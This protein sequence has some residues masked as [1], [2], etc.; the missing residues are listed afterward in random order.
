[1]QEIDLTL[2]QFDLPW[3]DDWRGT[4]PTAYCLHMLER[5]SDEN[6]LQLNEYLFGESHASP[7]A[8]QGRWP[9]DRFRLFLSHVHSQKAFVG[10][11]K[12]ELVSYAVEGFVAHADITPTAEWVHE[13]ELALETC[14]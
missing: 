4:D 3:T 7:V 6:L 14:D 2:R 5:G 9:A 12:A 1:W 13:I 10:E 8:G 11:L